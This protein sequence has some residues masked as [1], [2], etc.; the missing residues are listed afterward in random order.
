MGE[1]TAIMKVEPYQQQQRAAG[2]AAHCHREVGH[3]TGQAEEEKSKTPT[4][5]RA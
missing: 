4:A 3:D 1:G 2:D 5:V